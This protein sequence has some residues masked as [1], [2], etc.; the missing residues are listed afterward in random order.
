MSKFT[1]VGYRVVIKQDPVTEKSKGGIILAQSTLDRQQSGQIIGTLM[2]VG[3][4][5][6]TGPDWGKDDRDHLQPGTK[7]IY[8]RYSGQ[9]FTLDPNDPDAERY[10]IC[11]DSD[12]FMPI[13]EGMNLTLK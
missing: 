6:F 7:V 2:A 10:E 1:A 4:V 5:A 8:R 11:A 9:P 12:V 3:P 13:P